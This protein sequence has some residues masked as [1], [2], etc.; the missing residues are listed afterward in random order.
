MSTQDFNKDR[1]I[2]PPLV[3]DE[4]LVRA[5]DNFRRMNVHLGEDGTVTHVD[6]K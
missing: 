1:W 3:L 2:F 6:F 4:Q 5:A